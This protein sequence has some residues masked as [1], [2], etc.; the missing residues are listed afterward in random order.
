MAFLFFE[1]KKGA[2]RSPTFFAQNVLTDQVADQVGVMEFGHRHQS[3]DK[4]ATQLFCGN[5]PQQVQN[6]MLH[7]TL[8]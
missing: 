5:R 1:Y 2:D 6:L 8:L 3:A 4:W 7:L